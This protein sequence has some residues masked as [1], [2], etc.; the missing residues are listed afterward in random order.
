MV[1]ANNPATQETKTE[2]HEFKTSL[3][4]IGSSRL[5]ENVKG[6]RYCNSSVECFSDTGQNLMWR[7]V[8]HTLKFGNL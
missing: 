7:G 6:G 3:G 8:P 5:T 4:N 1:Q 2:G